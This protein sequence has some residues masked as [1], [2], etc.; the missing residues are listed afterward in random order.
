MTKKKQL[1]LHE[2]WEL[3]SQAGGPATTPDP[4]R[5]GE[6]PLEIEEPKK[7]LDIYKNQET[8]DFVI[9]RTNEFGHSTKRQFISEQ[10]LLEGLDAYS[11]TDLSEYQLNVSEDLQNTVAGRMQKGQA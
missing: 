9:K 8:G 11:F 6:A 5:A 1:T 7:R 3:D 4:Q 2:K 10:G